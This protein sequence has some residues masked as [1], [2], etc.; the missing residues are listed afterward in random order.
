MTKE[1]ALT[2][3][4][5]PWGIRTVRVLDELTNS[6]NSSNFHDTGCAYGRIS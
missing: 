6:K 1:I 2:F 5:G 3:D 4:D